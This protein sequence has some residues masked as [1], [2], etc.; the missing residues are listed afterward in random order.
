MLLIV[1]DDPKFLEQTVDFLDP[2]RGILLALNA[3]QAKELA[4]TVGAWFSVVLI[5]LDLPGQDGFSLISEFREHF[6]ELPFD[7]HQR[8]P[9]PGRA[10]KC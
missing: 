8:C 1:D 4:A 3:Q 5:D 10:R 6:P 2:G 9:P 7:C